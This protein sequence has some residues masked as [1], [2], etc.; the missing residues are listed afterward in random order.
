MTEK[1]PHPKSIADRL[2]ELEEE[3][4]THR[5]MLQVFVALLQLVIK[6]DEVNDDIFYQ[7]DLGH[8]RR[9]IKASE[10]PDELKRLNLLV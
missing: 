8:V 7:L 3:L 4:R 2:K 9:K 10:I 1:E 6:P 5:W